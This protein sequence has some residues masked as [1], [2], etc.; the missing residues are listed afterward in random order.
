M[1]SFTTE[2]LDKLERIH[3]L[4]DLAS[5]AS[6]DGMRAEVFPA[7]IAQ[8]RAAIAWKEQFNLLAAAIKEQP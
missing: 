3:N 1:I 7:L 6:R 8:A 4:T 2:Q 5:S